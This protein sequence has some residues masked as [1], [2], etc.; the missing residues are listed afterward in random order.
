MT[1]AESPRRL[2]TIAF[3]TG[4]PYGQHGQIIV[5]TLYDDE[6]ITFR[7]HTRMVDG[8]FFT[9]ALPTA[10]AVM[11]AVT[12]G[13]VRGSEYASAE[14]SWEDNHRHNVISDFDFH[15]LSATK[16]LPL[17]LY[18][19]EPEAQYLPAE[20]LVGLSIE[21]LKA[22]WPKFC[23]ANGWDE[24]SSADGKLADMV[25]IVA[26][27]K[28]WM[29]AFIAQWDAESGAESDA[30]AVWF[31]MGRDGVKSTE[32]F[33]SESQTE[34][35]RWAEGYVSRGDFGGWG[36]IDVGNGFGHIV[37]TLEAP[38]GDDDCD[39][40]PTDDNERRCAN[41]IRAL[42]AYQPLEDDMA[43]V[44]AD[45]LTDLRH[46]CNREGINFNDANGDAAINFAAEKGS[47]EL[48]A[49]PIFAGEA[50]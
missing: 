44:V 11:Q 16:H 23:K 42:D 38:E 15:S 21:Q 2:I 34:A 1:A 39:Y 27:T 20:K 47:I 14:R 24:R 5:A 8:Q 30:P 7:D 10:E 41:A 22:Q 35:R 28:E 50:A 32:L 36:L 17:T 9:T 46:L 33:T 18:K 45:L 3:N 37:L 31:V 49:H 29:E 19:P 12:Q 43:D 25:G 26:Q 13:Y 4:N 48:T 40:E 6:T